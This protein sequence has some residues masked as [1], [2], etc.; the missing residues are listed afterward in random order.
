MVQRDSVISILGIFQDLTRQKPEQPGP[1]SVLT[2][3]GLD[4][5]QGPP[6]L[7]GSVVV[8]TGAY[9]EVMVVS[10]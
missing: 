6:S 1:C 5:S 9:H 10:S 3:V 2:Q 8:C 4:V 7:C